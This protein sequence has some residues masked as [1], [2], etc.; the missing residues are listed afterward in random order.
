MKIGKG[1]DF[2][3]EGICSKCGKKYKGMWILKNPTCK[4]DGYAL[5]LSPETKQ[6]KR[7]LK[8]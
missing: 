6:Y 1:K 8:K 4:D 5:I 7:L 3:P 2:I